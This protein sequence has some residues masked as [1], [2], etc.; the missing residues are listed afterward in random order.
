MI[1]RVTVGGP[2]SVTVVVAT[3]EPL[4]NRVL[5]AL[6]DLRFP[7]R[8]V[9]DVDALKSNSEEGGVIYCVEPTIVHEA[10]R[11]PGP[12]VFIPFRRGTGGKEQWEQ[13]AGAVLL[14]ADRLTGARLLRALV[15]A[16]L[17]T[18][19][20]FV[21]P[22]LA[23]LGMLNRVPQELVYGF[24]RDPSSM[25]RLRDVRRVMNVGRQKA[26]ALVRFTGR[27]ERAEHLLTV[28]RCATWV[29]LMDQGL[30]RPAIEA[31]LGMNDRAAFRR[32]CH[33]AQVPVPHEGASLNAFSA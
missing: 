16:S 4:A 24:L 20:D 7:H 17:G 32:A 31:Y 28:L 6:K 8:R 23:Q 22:R 13:P 29:L 12:A 3:S 26:Q 14:P 9:G 30:A 33:R 25:M 5:T 2:T 1:E 11:L 18:N 21:A 10:T 27:F 19:V 15:V